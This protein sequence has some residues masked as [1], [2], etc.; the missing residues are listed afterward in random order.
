MRS[1]TVWPI[2]FSA[3]IAISI[4]CAVGVNVGDAQTLKGRGDKP[5]LGCC[6]HCSS[7]MCSGCSETT[8]LAAGNCNHIA[9]CTTTNDVNTCKPAPSTQTDQYKK[10]R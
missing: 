8:P 3:C 1:I 9:N 4:V 7:V 5:W 6:D 10:S 2:V